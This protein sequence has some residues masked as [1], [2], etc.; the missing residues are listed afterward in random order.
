M[1]QYSRFSIVSL[2]LITMLC[3][4][5]AQQQGGGS[6][7][8][9]SE[10]DQR[11]VFSAE[12]QGFLL[13][14]ARK[15]LMGQSIPSADSGIAGIEGGGAVV[16]VAFPPN[17]PVVTVVAG[18]SFYEN[19]KKAVKQTAADSTFKT[20]ISANLA[21]ARIKVGVINS[22]KKLSVNTERENKQI[23][24]RLSK[25]MEDGLNGLIMSTPEKTVYQ[26]P[27]LVFYEGWG[28]DVTSR[29]DQRNRRYGHKL[30]KKQLRELS[31]SAAGNT[32]AWKNAKLYKFTTITF[33]DKYGQPGTPVE[34]HRAKNMI[35]PLTR[36]SIKAAAIANADYLARIVGEDGK[37]VYLYF[38]VEDQIFKG[39][40][41]V[42]HAGSVFGL[43]EASNALGDKKYYEA[44]RK[45]LNYL[46]EMTDTPDEAPGIAIVRDKGRSSLGA[47]ALVAMAYAALPEEFM[48]EKDKELQ[49]KLGESILYFRMPQKGYFYTTF[50][51]ALN[52][53]APKEQSRYYPGEAMLALVRLYEKTGDKKWWDAAAEISPGQKKRWQDAGHKE[54]GNYCWVGQA[55]A[56]MARL[57]KDPAMR[58]EYKTLAYSHADAVI[59]H[60]FVPGHRRGFYPDYLGAADNSKPPRTTPTSARSESVA[61]NYL[62]AKFLSDVESQKKYGVALLRALHFVILNQFTNEN[63]WFMPYPEKAIGGVRGSLVA[64]D[65]RIDYNQ[66]VLS[67]KI[68]GQSV[69]DDLKELGV[70]KYLVAQD[71]D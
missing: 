12:Q 34:S 65:I 37:F 55:W 14:A 19:F 10:L 7:Y 62:L 26:I 53:K 67:S 6:R 8:E 33:I 15:G 18:D 45:A 56:R 43:F 47:N 70:T 28:I 50:K 36:E 29:S 41:T 13:S 24:R 48:T 39:Y 69:V 44:G 4:G 21:D 25:V 20:K 54:V 31:K 16:E 51:Q 42:R 61:E 46:L 57:E 58:E 32:T 38:P 49:E 5:C 64:N 66:H 22:V 17:K 2:V 63:T 60:Q 1:S 23:Y 68:N 35:E 40:G 52:K 3:F 71:W 9:V 30:V 11:I 27:E 59:K